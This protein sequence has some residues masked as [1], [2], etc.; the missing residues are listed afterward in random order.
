MVRKCLDAWCKPI[1]IGFFWGNYAN[2]KGEV[3]RSAVCVL[4]ACSVLFSGCAPA[5]K[6]HN[7]VAAA[8]EYSNDTYKQVETI[9]SPR[10]L[11][12]NRLQCSYFY[13]WVRANYEAS[14]TY[15][16]ELYLTY[17]GSKGIKELISRNGDILKPVRTE[18]VD[19]IARTSSVGYKHCAI[20]EV[21]RE[22]LASVP[23]D[24]SFRIYTHEGSYLTITLD[25]MYIQGFFVAV[26]SK[27]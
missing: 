17:P 15:A 2:L 3:M 4:L 22:F 19:V 12:G 18:L 20:F 21:Q 16:I 11:I 8:C 5:L 24:N 9:Y 13:K 6:T 1:I 10:K 7:D 26:D 23:A 25:S 14:G 27:I